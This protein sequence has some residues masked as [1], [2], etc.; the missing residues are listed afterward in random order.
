GLFDVFRPNC[1]S[2]PKYPEQKVN[3]PGA[4]YIQWWDP[5]T[6][7]QPGAMTFG[8]CSNGVLRGPRYADVDLSVHKDFPITEGKRLEFRSEFINLFNH[9]ILDFAGGTGAFSLNST[10]FGQINASQ[11]ER[12]VQFGLKFY[13]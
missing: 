2:A 8:T 11:G 10:S 3:V 12:N 6:F 5:T 13:Y 9:P 1:L 4:G 7:A